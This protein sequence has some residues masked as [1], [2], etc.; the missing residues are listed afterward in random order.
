MDN[1]TIPTFVCVGMLHLVGKS[2]TLH[3][4]VLTSHIMVFTIT[5]F[6]ILNFIYLFKYNI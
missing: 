5:L 2:K 4:M 1:S 6:V 3:F